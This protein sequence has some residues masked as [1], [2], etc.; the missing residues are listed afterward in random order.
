DLHTAIGE[1]REVVLPDGSQLHLNTATRVDV[2]FNAEQRLIRLLSGEILVTTAPDPAGRSFENGSFKSDSFESR[3]FIVQTD[4]GRIR[5][6]GT[7]FSVQTLDR[8][9]I[10]VSVY[11]H[12]VAIQ[13]QQSQTETRLE[14][15]QSGEFDTSRLQSISTQLQEAPAWT[16]G[17]IISD[18][19][20]LEDFLT[21]LNR[22][23][24]GLL[25]CDPAVA[26]LRISGVFQLKDTDQVLA[27]VTNTLP[28]RVQQRT[29]YWIT[30]IPAQVSKS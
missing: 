30:L 6:L 12:A 19:Q 25:R 20:R 16:R 14:Q 11:E 27:A 5:A 15:G 23:R 2:N 10:R 28:V 13:P 26:D 8:N 24:P 21:E 18:D 22:Y 29:R 9:Q 1:H 17:Q 3:P 4:A 7:R